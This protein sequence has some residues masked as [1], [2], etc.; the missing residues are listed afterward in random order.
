MDFFAL[1]CLMMFQLFPVNSLEGRQLK[2]IWDSK[3]HTLHN[4]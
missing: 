2:E 4:K 1:F 3:S